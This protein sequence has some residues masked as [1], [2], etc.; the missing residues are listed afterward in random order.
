MSPIDPDLPLREGLPPLVDARTRL[1][2][3]GSFPGEASLAAGQYY[4]HPRNQFWPL[5]AAVLGG[6]ADLITRPYDE[7]C[8]WLLAQGV[9]LWDVHARCR[10]PGS[11]DAD[12]RDAQPN[13]LRQLSAAAPGLRGL[14]FHGGEAARAMRHGAALGL[15]MFR[16]PSSS[17]ANAGWSF[18]RKRVAWQQ[19]FASA[20]LA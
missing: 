19:V 20:G 13:D 4:G 5:V 9:G 1:V 3:L 17:P 10:R 2:V 12:I 15:P 7:R 16:L 18:E 14:A 6:P 11:L 8:A